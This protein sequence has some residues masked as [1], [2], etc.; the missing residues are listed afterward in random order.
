LLTLVGT[1]IG[2]LAFDAW[3]TWRLSAWVALTS[4]AIAPVLMLI[5]IVSGQGGMAQGVLAGD[6]MAAFWALLLCA[7]GG[8]AILIGLGHAQDASRSAGGF[9]ALVLLAVAGALIVAQSTHM[10][11]LAI[12]LAVLHVALGALS[13]PR[14]AWRYLAV[15]GA[16]LACFC[17]GLA[18]LYGATGSMQIDVL[19]GVLHRQVSAGAAG[20]LSPN[21]LAALGLGAIGAGLG[22]AMGIVPFHAWL[23]G[24]CQGSTLPGACLIACALPGA[25]LAAW[26][27]LGEVFA[28]HLAAGAAARPLAVLGALSA[29][30]GYASALRSRSLRRALAGLVTAQSGTWLWAWAVFLPDG[31]ARLF[32]LLLGHSLAMFCLWAVVASTGQGRRVDLGDIA[33]LGRR[34]PLLAAV[35]TLCL[36]NI[37]GMPPLA[38]ALGQLYL[39]RA[40]MA[41]GHGWAVGMAIAGNLLAWL[42]CGRVLSVV[43]GSRAVWVRPS[44]EDEPLHVAPEMLVVALGAAGSLAWIGL[45]APAV[46]GWIDSLLSG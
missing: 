45:Y 42:L 21:P 32:Y 36:L 43:E 24:S 7:A 22:L 25:A 35:L 30:S 3:T 23:P 4:L 11:S 44:Q 27:R 46:I 15:H 9:H 14:G 16:G 10:L 2:I 37:V 12:G 5:A 1:A 38:G 19:A 13:G 40:A 33:G 34:H 39:F 17:F 31:R 28:E 26:V 29:V 8:V 41:G 20:G 18:M 6:G